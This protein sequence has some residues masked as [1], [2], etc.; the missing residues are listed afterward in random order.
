MDMHV[1]M[2]TRASKT[3]QKNLYQQYMYTESTCIYVPHVLSTHPWTLFVISHQS[4]GMRYICF[5]STKTNMNN[6]TWQRIIPS[7]FNA[8]APAIDD[9]AGTDLGFLRNGVPSMY[10]IGVT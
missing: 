10:F 7:G 8:F 6:E 3:S 9:A 2:P 1:H 4:A 5:P